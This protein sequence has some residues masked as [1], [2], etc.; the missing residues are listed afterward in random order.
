MNKNNNLNPKNYYIETRN[1]VEMKL[2]MLNDNIEFTR[3]S[4]YYNL[5][6]KDNN[7][8]E[9]YFNLI[10]KRK[11]KDYKNK[12][13]LFYTD[14]SESSEKLS[15]RKILLGSEWT[16]AKEWTIF[17]WELGKYLEKSEENLSIFISYISTEIPA[18]LICLSILD[19]RYRNFESIYLDSE[20]YHDFELRDRISYLDSSNRNEWR[21]AQVLKVEYLKG[22]P[23]EFNPYLTIEIAGNKKEPTYTTSISRKQWE[24]KIRKGGKVKGVG[25]RGTQVR[26]NDVIS[27]IISDRYGNSVAERLRVTPRCHVNLIGRSAPMFFLFFPNQ[28][29]IKRP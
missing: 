29:K 22:K 15:Y 28:I 25:G 23:E 16:E 24:N 21:D 11:V 1:I 7:E 10:S 8:I 13:A 12:E 18:L 17:F 5:F 27:E 2:K 20:V 26:V 19:T 14:I 9:S 6:N 4:F 3:N